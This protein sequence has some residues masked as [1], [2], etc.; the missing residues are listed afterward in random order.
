MQT[1]KLFKNGNSQA[2]RLP[3][4]FRFEGDEVCVKQVG[5]VVVLYELNSRWRQLNEAVGQF[6]DDFMADGRGDQGV[7]E[8]RPVL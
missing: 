7:S 5:S 2:I 1:A 3:K 4:E 8:E 6:T